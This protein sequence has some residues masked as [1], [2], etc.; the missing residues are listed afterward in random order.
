MAVSLLATACLATVV[1]VPPLEGT[2]LSMSKVGQRRSMRSFVK[3][4]CMWVEFSLPCN[5]HTTR[6]K[7]VLTSRER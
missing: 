1:I 2:H 5:F 3:Y 6:L 4:A 7:S